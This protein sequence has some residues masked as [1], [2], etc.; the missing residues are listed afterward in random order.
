[1]NMQEIIATKRKELGL[2]FEDIG[3]HVGVGKSTVKKWESGAIKN[4]RRDKIQKLA[5]I[6]HVSPAFLM[7][8]SEDEQRIEDGDIMA[9]MEDEEIRITARNMSQLSPDQKAALKNLAQT[10]S[11]EA[12]RRI[13]E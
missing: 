9:L 4:M 7:G 3:R 8:W 12:D 6:L 2:S 10:M 5:E 1:M 11:N 13:K